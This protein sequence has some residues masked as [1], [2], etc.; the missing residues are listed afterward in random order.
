MTSFGLPHSI[1]VVAYLSLTRMQEVVVR[2]QTEIERVSLQR[3]NDLL[4]TQDAVIFGLAGLADSRDPE[5]G[6][7]LERIA[8]Y[9]TCLAT[10]LARHPGYRNQITGSLSIRR[11]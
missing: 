2:R 6:K 1:S 3:H 4:R 8:G 5:T 10:A 9:S 7:H 11:H